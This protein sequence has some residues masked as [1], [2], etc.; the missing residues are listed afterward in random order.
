MFVVHS[1]GV[2]LARFRFALAVAATLCAAFAVLLSDAVP[3]MVALGA[4]A[5]GLLIGGLAALVSCAWRARRSDSR[6]RA[7]WR[8]LAAAALVAVLGNVW[9]VATDPEP[10]S[11]VGDASI[12]IALLLSIVGLLSFP[13]ARRRGIDV[14]LMG[15]DAVVVSGAMLVIG[16]VLVYPRVVDPSAGALGATPHFL[17]FPVLDLVLATVAL[18]LVI[19][20]R[21]DR[22]VLGLLAGGF[23]MYAA[24]DLAFAVLVAEER[25]K[26]GT[27]LDLLWIAGYGLIAVAA[28]HP[29]ADGRP[30]P[31]GRDGSADVQGTLLISTVLVV[32]LVVQVGF[33][34]GGR[35]ALIQAVLWVVLGV[36]AGLRQTL[37]TRDNANLRR[38]L[39][40]RVLEQTTDLRRL[41][42]QTDVLLESVGD[43]IYGVDAEGRISLVNRAGALALGRTVEELL[44]TRIHESLQARRDPAPD[45][46]AGEY[47]HVRLPT[48][49]DAHS[50]ISRAIRDGTVSSGD[51]DV[52]MRADGSVFPVEV[53]SSPLV[54]DGEV[55]GAVVVFRDVTQRH[56]V[57]RLKAEFLSVVSH[58]LRTPLTSMRGSLGLLAG[59]AVE[60]LSPRVHHMV[61]VALGSAERL[62][63]LINDILDVERLESGSLPLDVRP[64]PARD[65]VEAAVSEVMGI[66]AEMDVRVE[67]QE[68]CG[69]VL[70]DRDRI[71]QTLTNLLGNA[72]KFSDTGGLVR[73]TATPTGGEVLF[74]VQDQGR[75]IPEAKLEAIFERFEQVDSSDARSKGG[76]GLGLPISRG[77]V[78]QHGGRIWAES[79]EGRG[80]TM[81]FTLPADDA[82]A[83]RC[84]RPH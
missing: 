4:S 54:D 5:V 38:D 27:Q 28:W 77:I 70:V 74:R 22:P 76:S 21:S 29:S 32:A 82:A 66:A 51:E 44:G 35:L 42:R 2:P 10:P 26:F 49:D 57:E 19:R 18:L 25:F 79:G 59:G 75:G 55:R 58:E 41:V 30:E 72:I 83:G 33:Y 31:E 65:L 81:S 67:V 1:R 47:A 78:E 11:Q 17:L 52:Y 8:I 56:E 7:S 71:I 68:V 16:L 62:T 84:A 53:T 39:E 23:L 9:V 3:D 50:Y 46:A 73:V 14:V 61:A 6:R 60:R 69:R 37:L 63:R 43:G 45:A 20:S 48:S 12:A 15:L 80:T 34:E 24:A 13:S 40:R 36:A 64:C